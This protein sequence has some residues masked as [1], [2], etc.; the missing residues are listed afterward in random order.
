VIRQVVQITKRPAATEHALRRGMPYSSTSIGS[1]VIKC[2]HRIQSITSPSATLQSPIQQVYTCITRYR[3][4]KPRTKNI[5]VKMVTDRGPRDGRLKIQFGAPFEDFP[6]GNSKV[7]VCRSTMLCKCWQRS[8]Y[9]SILLVMLFPIMFFSIL[10][11][12]AVLLIMLLLGCII[13]SAT[14][15]DIL[16]VP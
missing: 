4:S 2:R 3:K 9:P 7:T 14:T 13:T 1:G 11:L 10:L 12:L 5:Q 15:I 8:Q 16:P 6:A